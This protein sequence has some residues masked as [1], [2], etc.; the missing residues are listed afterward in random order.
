MR[1]NPPAFWQ[2]DELGQAPTVFSVLRLLDASGGAVA[3]TTII[4]S[5]EKPGIAYVHSWNS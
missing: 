3:G 2:P 1:R 4:L 5:R